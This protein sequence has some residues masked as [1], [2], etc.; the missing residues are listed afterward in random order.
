MLSSDRGILGQIYRG[1]YKIPNNIMFEVGILIYWHE[2]VAGPICLWEKYDWL[3]HDM[4]INVM[5]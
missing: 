3:I 4:V 2:R 1:P 5:E